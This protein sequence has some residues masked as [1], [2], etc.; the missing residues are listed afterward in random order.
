M[1]SDSAIESTIRRRD[2]KV[3]IYVFLW[4]VFLLLLFTVGSSA[5]LKFVGDIISVT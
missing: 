2:L 5:S 4:I 3:E 1:D